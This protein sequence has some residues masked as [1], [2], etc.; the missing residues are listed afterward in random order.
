MII[1]VAK[2]SKEKHQRNYNWENQQRIFIYNFLA[3][4]IQIHRRHSYFCKMKGLVVAKLCTAATSSLASCPMPK[5]SAKRVNFQRY[6]LA[7]SVRHRIASF[8]ELPGTSYQQMC[9]SFWL[10]LL[11]QNVEASTIEFYLHHIRIRFAIWVFR[12]VLTNSV[13]S[14]RDICP[15]DQSRSAVQQT[16]PWIHLMS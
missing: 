10:Y 15:K 14:L 13:F 1:N 3:E 9:Q 2:H 6:L 11:V 16:L 7:N 5:L 4:D 8:S 12:C